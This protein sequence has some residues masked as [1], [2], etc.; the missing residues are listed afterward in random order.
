[1]FWYLSLRIS[2]ENFVVTLIPFP[3]ISITFWF[4]LLE[5]PKN[6][7]GI[8]RYAWGALISGIVAYVVSI[9]Y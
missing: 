9:F 2:K 8:M 6:Q 4:G 1:M 5:V 3:A 7:F